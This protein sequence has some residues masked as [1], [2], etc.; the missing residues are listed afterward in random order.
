SVL[1]MVGVLIALGIF[2]LVPARRQM[3]NQGSQPSSAA[4]WRE[5]FVGFVGILRHRPTWAIGIACALTYIPLAMAANWLP[6]YL[7]SAV[8]LSLRHAT[9]G[10]ALFY[11]GIA[12]GCPLAGL[13]ADRASMRRPILALGA[14]CTALLTWMLAMFGHHLSIAGLNG[15]LFVWGLS[16]STYVLGYPWAAAHHPPSGAG[17]AIAFINFLGMLIAGFFVSLFGVFVAALA[18]RHALAVPSAAEFR[19]AL[20]CTAGFLLVAALIHLCIPDKG[21]GQQHDVKSTLA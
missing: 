12:V 17:S 21:I 3:K 6:R 4:T 15:L 16:V 8:G 11:F 18:H 9:E 2:L 5:T 19:L 13:W 7:S 20:S 1:A 10:T 14:L